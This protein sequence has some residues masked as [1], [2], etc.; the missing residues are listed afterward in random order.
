MVLMDGG[1]LGVQHF[2]SVFPEV[3]DGT[4][5]R[6]LLQQGVRGALQAYWMAASP[7]PICRCLL[8][9]LRYL[10]LVLTV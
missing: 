1:P 9:S 6:F 4:I 2:F 5:S 7:G 3:P 10:Y 8:R